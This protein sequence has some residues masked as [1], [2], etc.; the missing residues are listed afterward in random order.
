M[1]KC[2]QCGEEVA[3]VNKYYI[4]TF[5]NNSC[6]TKFRHQNESMKDVGKK[7]SKILTGRKLSDKHVENISKSRIGN[8]SDKHKKA[9]RESRQNMTK[10]ERKEKFGNQG[11]SHPNFGKHHSKKTRTKIGIKH[12]DKVVSKETREKIRKNNIGK[13]QSKETRE[14]RFEWMNDRSKLEIAVQKRK[15]TKTKNGTNKHSSETRKKQRQVAVKRVLLNNGKFPSYNPEGIEFFKSYDKLNNTNG[16]YATHPNEYYIKELGYWPD[17][18]NFE[19]KI[20]MEYDEKYHEKQKVKDDIR[21]KEIK[22]FYPNF[23]F[24]RIKE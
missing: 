17:Y 22:E 16:Q 4:K 20:I 23:E 9:I 19:K 14:K 12:K 1:I 13:K 10:E 8:S 6:A 2:K 18:I 7:I 21:E 11:E 24:I 3:Q 15:E 5:C